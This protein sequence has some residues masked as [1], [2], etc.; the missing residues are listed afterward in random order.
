MYNHVKT[1]MWLYKLDLTGLKGLHELKDF[2]NI[3][4]RLDFFK[5]ISLE[6]L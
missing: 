5:N 3:F 4:W 1:L 6:I 2:I